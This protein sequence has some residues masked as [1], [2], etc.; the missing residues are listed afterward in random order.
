MLFQIKDASFTYPN[1]VKAFE[2][3]N[4]SIEANECICICGA[5]GSGKSTLL[6]VIAGILE[7]E[8][9]EIIAKKNLLELSSLLFQEPDMQ[10]LG[11]NIEEELFLTRTNLSEEEVEK[12]FELLDSFALLKHKDKDIDKL[13]FGQKRKL[14]LALC[15]L[16]EPSLL[17]LDEPTS[18]LD[19]PAQKQLREILLDLKKQKEMSLCI[20]CHDIEFFADLA[21]KVLIIENGKQLFW[22]SVENAFNFLENNPEGGIKLPSYWKKDKKIQ[23]WNE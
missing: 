3:I 2:E 4:F 9:G 12:A 11:Q 10:L 1:N 16:Q 23:S 14:C 13:S 17:L 15:L 18:G 7:L 21:D 20:I 5:N 19:F 22:G 6:R 8:H